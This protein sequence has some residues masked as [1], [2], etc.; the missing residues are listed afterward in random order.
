MNG[1]RR[2][3]LDVIS[4]IA[5]IVPPIWVAFRLVTGGWATRIFFLMILTAVAAFYWLIILRYEP[6]MGNAPES[7]D[8]SPRPTGNES[9]PQKT[10]PMLM[11]T[12]AGGYILVLML[13]AIAGFLTAK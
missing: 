11:A 2:K 1:R 10:S 8:D 9:R 3:P 4:L 12:I 5:T 6:H 7:D 13:S